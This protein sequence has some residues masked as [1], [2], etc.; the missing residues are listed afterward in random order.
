MRKGTNYGLVHQLINQFNDHVIN[1][2]M[3]FDKKDVREKS[4]AVAIQ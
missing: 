4:P 3:K 1:E 2:E